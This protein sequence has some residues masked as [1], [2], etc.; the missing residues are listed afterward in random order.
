MKGFD[1]KEKNLEQEFHL[2]KLEGRKTREKQFSFDFILQRL[3]G[4]GKVMCVQ[5]GLSARKIRWGLREMM[6]VRMNGNCCAWV[7]VR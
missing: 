1:V 5:C 2:E 4:N 7:F 3:A 6:R